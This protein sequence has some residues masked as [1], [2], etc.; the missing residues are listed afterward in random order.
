VSADPDKV[1]AEERDAAEKRFQQINNGNTLLTDEKKRAQY[2]D[3]TTFSLA[4]VHS[5][6]TLL[7]SAS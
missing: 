5:A 1:P 6:Q 3:G 4:V 2:D 7:H